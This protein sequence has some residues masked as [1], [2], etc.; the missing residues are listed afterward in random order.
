MLKK[1]KKRKK[2]E[3]T[4]EREKREKRK[5]TDAKIVDVLGETIRSN[6]VDEQVGIPLHLDFQ[7][8]DINTC[9][10][11]KGTYFEM[12]SEYSI[13]SLYFGFFEKKKKKKKTSVNVI[14]TPTALACTLAL[15][16]PSTACR[17]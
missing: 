6:I 8:Y 9:E 3:K 16:L 7:I 10:P 4:K 11:I 13:F 14:K 17:G 2:K 5:D 1:K 12:W 15:S